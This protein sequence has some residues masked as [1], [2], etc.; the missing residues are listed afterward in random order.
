MATLVK[1]WQS[2]TWYVHQLMGDSAYDNY[3]ARHRVVHP[4]HEPMTK[5]EFWRDRVQFDETNHSTGCC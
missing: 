2:F 4:D 3:L 1:A 5:R